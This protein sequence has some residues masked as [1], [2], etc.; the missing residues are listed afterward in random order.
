MVNQSPNALINPALE[1][2]SQ[3]DYTHRNG[4]RDRIKKRNNRLINKAKKLILVRV[5]SGWCLYK[6][7]IQLGNKLDS[8][9]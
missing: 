7:I 3:R 5:S 9:D 6:E 4:H 2:P 8:C 1:D